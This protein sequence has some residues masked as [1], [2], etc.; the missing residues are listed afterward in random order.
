MERLSRWSVRASCASLRAMTTAPCTYFEESVALENAD[1]HGELFDLPAKLR[2]SPL[3]RHF[4]WAP[5]SVLHEGDRRWQARKRQWL[6]LGTHREIGRAENLL[7]YSESAQA[8]GGGTSV[9]DPFLCELAYRWRCPP[10]GAVL[11]P[12]AGG[13]VRGLQ[14]EGRGFGS[15]SAHQGVCRLTGIDVYLDTPRPKG[16]SASVNEQPHG[17]WASVPRVS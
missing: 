13:S 8:Q 11:D 10:G 5:V 9:F 7:G 14:G 12:F 4:G 1:Q 2:I 17:S 16:E 6:E 3:N 15:L